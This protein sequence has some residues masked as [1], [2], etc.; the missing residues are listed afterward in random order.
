MRRCEK[1]WQDGK[2]QKAASKNGDLRQACDHVRH[3]DF[4]DGCVHALHGK[5]SECVPVG[6]ETVLSGMTPGPGRTML[7][8]FTTFYS[9]NEF[10]DGH[11][12]S[13]TTEF[14]R[15]VFANAFRAEHGWNV[16]LWGGTLQSNVAIPLIYQ[17]LHVQPGK[18]TEFGVGNIGI[19]AF[20]VAYHKRNLHWFYECS[21]PFCRNS[22]CLGAIHPLGQHNYAARPAAGFTYHSDR[23]KVEMSSREQS[24]VNCQNG[25]S[26]YQSGN[27]FMQEYAVMAVIAKTIAI[28]V[29]GFLLSTNE[30]RPAERCAGERRRTA[31]A[32]FRHRATSAHTA[33]ATR[34]IS[35][36]V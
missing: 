4:G 6:V 33:R 28:G 10:V 36:Q 25:E 19:G 7:F 32:R 16:H 15:R 9:A 21:G 17:Q 18:F 35:V 20:G 29:N 34:S 24:I 3:S 12:K 14:K 31:W 11:A 27:E 2:L 1:A 8:E 23:G 26:Q 22:L 13:M 5:W 30:R